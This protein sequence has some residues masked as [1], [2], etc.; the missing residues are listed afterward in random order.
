MSSVNQ[1]HG[2]RKCHTNKG[3]LPGRPK[4]KR[5]AQWA[6]HESILEEQ[7]QEMLSPPH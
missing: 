4:Q 1:G 2:R 3:S 6:S 5:L 7:F